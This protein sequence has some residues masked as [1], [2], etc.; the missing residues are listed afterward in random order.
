MNNNPPPPPFSPSFS[1]RLARQALSALILIALL[2]SALLTDS[3][4]SGA[5]QAAQASSDVARQRNKAQAKKPRRG[6]S[7]SLRN[8]NQL[9]VRS[10]AALVL[11]AGNGAVVYE[12]NATEIVPIASITKL[13]TAM[14]TLDAALDLNEEL[15]VTHDDID[16][17]KGS[18]SR[19]TVGTRLSREELLSLALM[20]SENR[21]AYTLSSNYPGGR[22]A[23]V[24]AMNRK[25][26]MLGMANTHFVDPTG[27]NAQN[28]SSARDLTKMVAAAHKYP[29]IREDT[30]T[31]AR[32]FLIGGRQKIFRNTNRLV[33]NSAWDIELSKTGY[34]HEAGKC[35]VMV[36]AMN[37]RPTII[38]LLDA[39]GKLT[40]AADARRIKNWIERTDM[41][42]RRSASAG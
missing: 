7:A 25:A 29:L 21:A 38:V 41:V 35:L 27:L 31:A 26:R 3:N 2:L 34:I 33:K 5:A 18:R 11:D 39:Q 23:F 1:H 30:T 28:T 16:T 24:A 42:A 20:A 4:K 37:D 17:V 8:A 19:L 40:R 13:M 6:K 36:A 10:A 9:L 15:T 12:K 22:T 14:V 32:S